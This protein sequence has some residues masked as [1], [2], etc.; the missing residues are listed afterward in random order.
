V[1]PLIQNS[2]DNRTVALTSA[3]GGF[4]WHAIRAGSSLIT[5]T[6]AFQ[7]LS[8]NRAKAVIEEKTIFSAIGMNIRQFASAEISER[9]SLREKSSAELKQLLRERS[10][11]VSGNKDALIERHISAPVRPLGAVQSL[12]GKWFMTPTEQ[13]IPQNG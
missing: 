13:F 7:V 3:Q 1:H 8:H 2:L 5:S 6:V 10:L 12:M 4:E 9:E 11:P